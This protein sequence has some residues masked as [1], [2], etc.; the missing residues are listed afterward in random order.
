VKESCIAMATAT[1]I[2]EAWTTFLM[3]SE[4]RTTRL[5]RADSQSRRCYM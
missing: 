4:C 2:Q 1:H 5:A 3:E